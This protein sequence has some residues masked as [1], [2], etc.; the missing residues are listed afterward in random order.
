MPVIAQEETQIE[1]RITTLEVKIEEL[2]KRLDNLEHPT[3][4][5]ETETTK[6]SKSPIFIKLID[7]TFEKADFMSNQFE[8]RICC[9]FQFK[10]NLEKEIRAFT[11][12]VIFKDLFDRQII[13]FSTT[14]EKKIKTGD[15]AKYTGTIH[16]NQ[17]LSNHNRFRSID[18]K[19]LIVDFVLDKVIY[20]DGTKEEFSQK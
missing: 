16:F 11:G 6:I 3:Q 1:E 15:T 10:N 4:K 19:D 14:V 9:I 5:I 2:E 7:K 17:F 20:A 18:K 13:G 12:K 8:D